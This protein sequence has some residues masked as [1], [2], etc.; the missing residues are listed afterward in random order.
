MRILI[1]S[2]FFLIQLLIRIN[3]H[4]VGGAYVAQFTFTCTMTIR[5]ITVPDNANYMYVEMTGAAAGSGG[6]G[7]PGYGARVQTY[8]NV[9]PGTLLHAIVGC[10]GAACPSPVTTPHYFPGGY[11][12]GGSSYGM[13]NSDNAG[14]GG[15]G[16]SDIR[17]GGISL[18]NRVI[19]AGG[20]G[21]Y[22]CGSSCG[23]MKGGDAGQN[24]NAGNPS[25]SSGCFSYNHNAGGGGT[26]N[27]GGPAGASAGAPAPTGGALGFGGNGGLGNS[28]GGGGGYY[29]GWCFYNCAFFVFV[30]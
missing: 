4:A 12:G 30:F 20:G 19:I 26:L 7:N 13:G 17:I 10:S 2:L 3:H 6:S 21:G 9:I 8:L 5:N 18:S 16:A 1:R 24:G 14:S 23:T 29:G 15:G 11:N 28:G 22:Y 25:P 27:S